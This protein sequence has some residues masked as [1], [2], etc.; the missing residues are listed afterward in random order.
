M[1]NTSD[2]GHKFQIVHNDKLSDQISRQLVEAIFSGRYKPGDQLPTERDLAGL[3]EV[4][5]VVVREALVALLSK[6]VLSTRQGS[7]TTV[8]PLEQWNTLDPMIMMLRDGDDTFDQLQE[9]R[10]IIEPELC[11]LAAERISPE[12]I[13][14]LRPQSVLQ[15]N[16]TI[17]QHIDHDTSFHM[18]IARAT[19]NTVLQIVMS[20]ISDLLRESRRRSYVNPQEASEAR[21]W[22]EK[23]FS[24]IE[25]HDVAGARQAMVGHMSQVKRA[26]EEYKANEK[27]QVDDL[28]LGTVRES[29]EPSWKIK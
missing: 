16:D 10:R 12:E 25:R 29:P 28:L 7:G 8:N 23:I 14:T 26:L 17:E 21:E 19:K 11:A 15:L 13:E 9:V 2:N 3:F 27:N 22:H 6:G 20:S 24:A 5:R 18:A 4:S 1:L